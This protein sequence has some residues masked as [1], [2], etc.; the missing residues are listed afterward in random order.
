MPR[1]KLFGGGKF[2]LTGVAKRDKSGQYVIT[3]SEFYP[4]M[5]AHMQEVVEKG[6]LPEE[7]IDR[8]IKQEIDPTL[9]ARRYLTWARQIPDLAW[10]DALVPF[11]VLAAKPGM[12][13]RIEQRAEALECARLW[14]T[15]AAKNL[16]SGLT[17][18]RILRDPA[19][20][21]GTIAEYRA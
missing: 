13:E 4:A 3:P 16:D 7:L 6:E 19:Y 5:I 17:R 12:Q 20:K 15:R 18:I 21:L 10:R 8:D 11:A 2:K 14:F 1:F 9:A